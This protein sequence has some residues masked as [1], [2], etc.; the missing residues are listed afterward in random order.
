MLWLP[1][2]TG[3]DRP[4]VMSPATGMGDQASWKWPWKTGLEILDLYVASRHGYGIL[5]LEV[6]Q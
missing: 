4:L 2:S 6:F 1:Y 5:P 3:P